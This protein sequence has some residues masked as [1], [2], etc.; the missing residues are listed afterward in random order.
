VALRDYELDLGLEFA[1]QSVVLV[2]LI[3]YIC[4]VFTLESCSDSARLPPCE[5]CL[6]L[7]NKNPLANPALSESTYGNRRLSYSS[8]AA[9]ARIHHM[10]V[11]ERLQLGSETILALETKNRPDVRDRLDLQRP[12]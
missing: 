7:N 6:L 12:I 4:W 3:L 5:P 1:G 8:Q 11:L 10:K 2:P 9:T